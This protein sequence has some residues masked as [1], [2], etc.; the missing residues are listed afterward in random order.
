[1]D[2]EREV[3]LTVAEKALGGFALLSMLVGLMLVAVLLGGCVYRGGR[4][5]DG[6]NLE[7]GICVPGTEWSIN[8]LSYTGGIKVAGNQD[9]SIV[10]SNEVDETNSYFGVVTTHR[11]TRMTSEISPVEGGRKE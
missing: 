5:V 10:V 9:T 7:I 8:A 1:M 2:A 11:K 4:V 6:S 3:P